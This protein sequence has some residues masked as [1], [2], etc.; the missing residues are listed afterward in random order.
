MTQRRHIR[1]DPPIAEPLN[2]GLALLVQG[3]RRGTQGFSAALQIWNE[4][5]IYADEVV[6]DSSHQ[7]NRFLRAA[8]TQYPALDQSML[9]QALLK[10]VA[11]LPPLLDAAPSRPEPSPSI[12][13]A[14]AQAAEQ[15]TK[16]LPTIEAKEGDLR[17]VTD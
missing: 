14:N 5:L 8:C 17:V 4:H 9:A 13:S 10:M 11:A 16:E 2:D 12:S 15:T 1:F 6:L 7:R 3:V